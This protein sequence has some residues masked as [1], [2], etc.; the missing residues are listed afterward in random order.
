MPANKAYLPSGGS[1]TNILS[2][3]FGS[4]TGIETATQAQP[5]QKAVFDLQGR[6]VE[7]AQKGL[8]IVNGKKVLVK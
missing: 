4:L 6:R 8:Y 7:K 1:S 2:L 3:T 5:G